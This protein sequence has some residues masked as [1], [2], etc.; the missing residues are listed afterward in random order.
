[1]EKVIVEENRLKNTKKV[2]KAIVRKV[3]G[4]RDRKHLGQDR[5]RISVGSTVDQQTLPLQHEACRQKTDLK[6]ERKI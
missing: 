6:T 3:V 5:S 2:F 1:M 4:G